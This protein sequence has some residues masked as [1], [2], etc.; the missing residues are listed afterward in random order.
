MGPRTMLWGEVNWNFERLHDR[1]FPGVPL[2][3]ERVSKLV[4]RG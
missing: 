1:Q 4:L 2:G 3:L